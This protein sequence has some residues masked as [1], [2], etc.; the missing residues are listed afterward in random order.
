[1]PFKPKKPLTAKSKQNKKPHK[2]I[3]S[4]KL[5][6]DTSKPNIWTEEW[7]ELS[8]TLPTHN[9]SMYLVLTYPTFVITHEYL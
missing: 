9:T 2:A 3:S 6:I 4:L 8:S 1:M 5:F 7:S